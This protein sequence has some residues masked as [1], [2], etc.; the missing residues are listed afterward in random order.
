MNGFVL[1]TGATG[2]QGGAV[3]RA[4]LADGVPVHALVRD[5]AAG[6]ARALAD[7]G[8]VLAHGDLD[9]PASL[10]AALDGAR[11]VF[12][13]QTPDLADLLGDGEIRHARHL[14][15]A[16]AAAGVGQIVHTSV[17]GAGD[18]DPVDGERWGAWMAHYWRCKAAAEQ[19]VRD[20]GVAH[21]TI[22]RPSTFMENLLPGSFY[23]APGRDDRLL[24]AVD[25]DTGQ[26][27]VAVDDIGAAAAAAF[28]DPDRFDRVELELAGDLR[29]FREA[30]AIVSGAWGRA[31]TLP[32]SPAAARSEGLA[33]AFALGQEFQ[34]A[35]PAPARPEFARALGLPTTTLREWAAAHVP[36][37]G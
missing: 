32:E 19:A 10:E 9:D 6:K 12:S 26:R 20:A 28:A 7:R 30:A 16:A 25:P 27:F 24:V 14:A 4:L 29:T 18:N 37:R 22:L 1:V 13:V 34:S 15:G 23:Y 17:S 36:V 33:D 11:G 3:V 31:V 21:R 8:V 35:H 5:P 2:K